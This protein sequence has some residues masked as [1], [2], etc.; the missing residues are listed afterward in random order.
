MKRKLY[1]FRGGY[2]TDL[3]P[4]QMDSNMLLAGT[5]YYYKG[6]LKKRPGWTNL[7]TDATVA[8]GTVRGWCRAY[9]NGA[10]YNVVALDNATNVNF[11]YGN[12]GAY[13][14]ID[15]DFDWTTGTQ[16]EMV[17]FNDAVVAVNGTDKPAI[18]YY[19]SAWTVENLETYDT[20]TRGND[21]WYAGQWDA[22]ETPEFV[23]DTTDAQSTTTTDFNIAST[24]NND[25]FYIA[26]V[27]V[28][29]KIV[30]KGAEQMSGSPVAEYAYY[31]G[32]GTWTTLSPATAPTWTAA[33]GDK[34]IEFN[35][36]L[37]SDGV[38]LWEKFG[39][40]TTQAD[41]TGVPGGALNRYIIRVR[42]TTAPSAAVDCDYFQIS[43][44]Q[45]LTQ[46]F[47]NDKPE[48]VVVHQNRLFLSTGNAFR[49]SPTNTLKGWFA[50]EIEYCVKGGKKIIA[51]ASVS[52][53]LAIMKEAGIYQYIGTTT[54]NFVLQFTACP[55][56]VSVRGVATVAGR[57]VYVAADGIR[58]FQDG[59]SIIVSRHIQTD[60]ANYTKTNACVADWDGG[61]VISFPTNSAILWADPDTLRQDDMGDGRVSFWKWTGVAVTRFE[62]ANG[63]GD[64][65]NLIGSENTRFI[66]ETTNGY[67]VAYDT[68]QTAITTTLQ[69]KYDSADEP[70]TRKQL[71]RVKLDLSKSGEW[72]LTM[73]ADEAQAT[74]TATIS[75]GTGTG[76]YRADIT[77]PYTL[78]RYNLSFTLVNSTTNP[79]EVYGVETEGY[80]RA[81]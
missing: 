55:G 51:M 77:P 45:Y 58:G 2:A 24:T 36:P 54:D 9:I 60:I 13:T 18:I 32:S 71:R 5:N 46:I 14:A 12:T 70:G 56:A 38:L 35:L 27:T 33:T 23:D 75:S 61:A 72:T 20:R 17:F 64:N 73:G 11:Y 28:F 31:A 34:T 49:F 62:H 53:Y 76:H 44:T 37:D 25:G 65:G 52:G 16:V 15:N 57:L 50:D 1:D 48:N 40:L 66:K 7:S 80:G 47:A 29:N 78:D 3:A 8:A 22:S 10:W 26:G 59:L 69:T 42:F 68:T 21:E 67:D 81:F 19:D 79:V 74:A 41:P 63:S 6:K 39:D 30:V 4:E 43:H